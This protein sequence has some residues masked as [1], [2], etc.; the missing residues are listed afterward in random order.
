VPN[1]HI[2]SEFADALI[3]RRK[4]A[5]APVLLHFDESVSASFAAERKE[6]LETADRL[7]SLFKSM[8]EACQSAPTSES[9]VLEMRRLRV[10]GIQFFHFLRASKSLLRAITSRLT[11]QAKID[12]YSATVALLKIEVST[13]DIDAT[14]FDSNE[15]L[16]ALPDQRD[17]QSNLIGRA[18]EL[19]I[20]VKA[21]MLPLT[22][23]LQKLSFQEVP[24]EYARSVKNLIE[25][26]TETI[27]KEQFLIL[28]LVVWR[29]LQPVVVPLGASFCVVYLLH[30]LLEVL[31]I[32]FLH[33]RV[34]FIIAIAVAFLLEKLFELI[35]DSWHLRYYRKR[36]AR[37]AG[38]LYFSEIRSRASLL[39]LLAL[40]EAKPQEVRSPDVPS[41]R[42][43]TGDEP[44]RK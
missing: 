40:S 32:D 26:A 5:L 12:G 43:G 44:P 8:L 17:A 23:T 38:A 25:S 10:R 42:S 9:L 31:G 6:L 34:P 33:L 13:S 11:A 16:R 41:P 1:D 7:D 30:M 4:S 20:F 15:L 14:L 21:C 37:T 3:E 28:A 2:F 27:Y 24:R 36:C 22:S 29:V 19:K 35:F 18:E 39:G